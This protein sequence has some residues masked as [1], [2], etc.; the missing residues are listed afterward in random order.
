MGKA[1]SRGQALQVSARV[2]TQVNWDELDGTYL[3]SEVL[4]LSPDEFGRR[5][6]FF[7]KG[8]ARVSTGN[9]KIATALFDP[10]SFIGKSWQGIAEDRDERSATLKEVDITKA[11]FVSCLRDGETLIRGEEK[12]RRLK[13]NGDIRLGATLFMG[14]WKDY[15]SDK[16]NSVLECAYQ[17]GIIGDYIDFFGNI[18]LGPSG[19]RRVL[20]LY[21][22]F[23]GKW[24]WLVHWLGGVWGVRHLSAVFPQV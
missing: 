4:E 6:T 11:K 15:Q 8:G 9:F 23:Y 16:E 12:L 21:R 20:S 14:L 3:Q 13:E 1:V 17:A 5:F 19:S 24:D 22:H 18:L 10:V 2:A 7:L